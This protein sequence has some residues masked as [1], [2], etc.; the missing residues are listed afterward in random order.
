MV[1]CLADL[2]DTPLCLPLVPV[3]ANRCPT[4]L[5]AGGGSLRAISVGFRRL[6]LPLTILD[7]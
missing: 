1:Q 2:E 3:G 7:W 5:P 4:D 6:W